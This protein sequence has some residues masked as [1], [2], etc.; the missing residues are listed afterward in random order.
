[1]PRCRHPRA[2]ARQHNL[3]SK[4]H[5]PTSTALIAGVHTISIVVPG[6]ASGGLQYQNSATD[7]SPPS[8]TTTASSTYVASGGD[9]GSGDSKPVLVLIHGFGSGAVL[10]FKTFDTL[11]Q[12]GVFSKVYALDWL[13]VGRSHRPKYPKNNPE[14][15]EVRNAVVRF[16]PV[17]SKG[18][19]VPAQ[20]PV[21]PCVHW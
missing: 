7:V 12:C 4:C 9:A 17:T 19:C 2:R 14:K 8:T 6:D 11:A 1:M 10:W 21:V 13:G 18:T 16:G 3:L 15:G 5:N 20:T